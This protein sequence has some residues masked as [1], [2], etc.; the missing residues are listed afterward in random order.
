MFQMV[1]FPW[2]LLIFRV[3]FCKGRGTG[4]VILWIK[5]RYYRHGTSLA[6]LTVHSWLIPI[7]LQYNTKTFNVN[8]KIVFNI[9]TQCFQ[10]NILFWGIFLWNYKLWWRSEVFFLS[11]CTNY[12]DAFMKKM[13]FTN[14]HI[15]M[16]LL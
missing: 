1:D 16:T 3:F 6:K 7:P 8:I 13:K 15:I 9:A 11:F 10:S 12:N 14:L 4:S 2:N 5:A